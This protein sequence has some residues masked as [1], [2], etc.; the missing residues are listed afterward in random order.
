LFCFTQ[1]FA[2]TQTVGLFTRI[3][4][5]YDS[6]YILFPP[7]QNSDTTYLINRCG[8]LIHKWPSTYTPGA[9]AY[10]LPD[11]SLLRAGHYPNVIFDSCGCG[12]G[13]IIE[14]IDWN[15]NVVWHYI[16]SDNSQVQSH[17]IFPL[18]NGNILVDV[19]ENISAHD[20]LAAG[21]DP[22]ILGTRLYSPKVIE[23]KPI[24]TSSAQIVWTWRL[25][26]HLI[27]DRDPVKPNYGI[28]SNHP[29]LVNINFINYAAEP[30]KA[31]DWT[32][33]NSV[34]YNPTLDQV[35]LSFRN[36]N[37]I[38]IIDHSTDSAM[39]AGHKGGKYSKGGD[40]IYR[41]GNPAVY[42]RGTTADVKLFEQHDP[43][44][45]TSGKYNG[46]IMIFNNGLGRLAPYG[47]TID[48]INPPIDS[49][50]NY[51]LAAG[52]TYGPSSSSYS[53]PPLPS[54]SFFSTNMGSAQVVPNGDILIDNANSGNFFEI[55]SNNNIVWQ[56]VNPVSGGAPLAQYKPAIGN[57]VYRCLFYPANYAAFTTHSMDPGKPIELNPLPNDCDST[58]ISGTPL[59]SAVQQQIAIYPN[60]STGIVTLQTSGTAAIRNIAIMD[61]AGRLL[62]T[63]THIAYKQQIDVSK[64]ADGIYLLKTE[65]VN[66]NITQTKLIR[67]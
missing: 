47:S 55:D 32:H 29:E 15:G 46:Q 61:M 9:D 53:Y 13:G 24:G 6:G 30:S 4:G 51:S 12:I 52:G 49:S 10:L 62:Q 54:T 33:L 59:I 64:L 45:I 25:W 50:G 48:I 16:I 34:A 67:Q 38:C 17:D 22:A 3:V 39:A 31:P 2:Q 14:R 35:L 18:P 27:Q 43:E 63:V 58:I 5:S 23:I 37:E 36:F 21:R 8:Q 19:W 1:V 40:L 7:Y 56:Y 11:G 41:W 28:V 60:P 57:S 66:G 65:D 44:W 20:A 26:D 42:G